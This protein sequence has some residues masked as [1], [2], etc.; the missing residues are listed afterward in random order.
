MIKCNKNET[1]DDI[2]KLQDLGGVGGVYFL[3]E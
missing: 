2:N 3:T 1:Y